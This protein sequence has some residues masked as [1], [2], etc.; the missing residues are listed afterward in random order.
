MSV[1]VRSISRLTVG[2]LALALALPATQALADDAGKTPL[3]QQAQWKI[4]GGEAAF[5]WNRH[6]MSDFGA[7][8]SA[9]IGGGKIDD[10]DYEAL[11]I[12]DASALDFNVHHRSFD[13]FAGG[14]IVVRG[15]FDLTFADGQILHLRD[16]RLTPRKDDPFLLDVV[17]NDGVAWFYIDKLMYD[18]GYGASPVLNIYTM[19]VRVSHALAQ[20]LGKPQTEGLAVADVRMVSHIHSSSG[21]VSLFEAP[22]PMAGEHWQGTPVQGVPGAIYQSD[23]FMH[24]IDGQVMRSRIGTSGFPE[25]VIAPNSTLRNN[26]NNGSAVV[27]FPSTSCGGGG[28]PASDP[29]G[30]STALYTA[31]IPWNTKFSGN[32]PPYNN[33]QHPFLIWNLFRIDA[34]G[35]IAQIG[36]SGVKHAFLTTNSSCDVVASS[37]Y[38]L[39]RGCV[40]TYS[41]GNN[42]S[43]GYLGVRDEILPAKGQW[44][45]C[46]SVF[47]N[48]CNNLND[49]GSPCVNLVGTNSNE[50]RDWNPRVHMV[51]DGR[52]VA[53]PGATYLLESWYIVRDDINIFNTM[54]TRPVTFSG[55]GTSWSMGNASSTEL[56]LGSAIDRLVPRGTAT[57]TERSSNIEDRDNGQAR[58]VSRVTDLGNGQWR[59]DYYVMNFDLAVGETEGTEPSL[60]V[61]SNDGF[62]R[63]RV[64]NEG[65]EPSALDFKDADR[66]AANDWVASTGNDMVE[67]Q[68]QNVGGSPVNALN[69]GTMYRFGFVVDRPADTQARNAVL[70]MPGGGSHSVAVIAPVPGQAQ[71][72]VRVERLD[73]RGGRGGEQRSYAITVENTG[74]ALAEDVSLNVPMATGLTNMSWTCVAP[75]GGCDPASGAGAVTTGYDLA[76]G[77]QSVTTVLGTVDED[78]PFVEVM[79]TAQAPGVGTQHASVIEPGGPDGVYKDGFDE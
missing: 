19:D 44:G 62:L 54:Q 70:A 61:N 74:F 51:V 32:N 78:L 24:R 26:R 46:G 48:D 79:A 21:D 53:V 22:A 59:Y 34:D 42:D 5:R 60:R 72:S 49:T 35:R 23:V 36:A 38:V 63:F 27:T 12:G 68:A 4:W 47:D 58:V 77:Q 64:P 6:L 31:D 3:T 50:C 18:I 29:L 45:R 17:G 41:T 8:V 39:Y 65:T 71:L 11:A 66:D 13:G 10:Y 1:S 20:R 40:D 15:G 75:G 73:A 67:W 16:F 37:S 30:T 56:K 28:C 43:I 33:D 7:K 9:A 69:W 2:A 55:S 57:A 52:D 76:P 14:A 25:I